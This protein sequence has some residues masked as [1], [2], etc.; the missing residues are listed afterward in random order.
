[1]PPRTQSAN[2]FAPAVIN[3][4][5]VFGGVGRRKV[6]IA[7]MTLLAF[8]IGMGLV[9][10]LKPVYTSAAKVLIQNLETPFDRVQPTENQRAEAIDDRIVASQISVL[11]SEDIGRRVIAALGLEN[12]SEFNALINGQGTVSK[13]G[14][15][16]G[17]GT[18]PAS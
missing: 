7:G 16:L 1:M 6:L 4:V 15:K 5:D 2:S 13:L 8:A 12:K 10:I 18:D 11:K 17:F 3:I 9:T 14:V